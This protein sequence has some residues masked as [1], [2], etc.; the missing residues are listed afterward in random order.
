MAQEFRGP[1]TMEGLHKQNNSS[2]A[3]RAFG[4]VTIGREGELGLMFTNPA[5]LQ[6]LAGVQ[7][8][9][10]G[11]LR[12]Q[13]LEQ[14]QQ[15]APVRYYPNLSLLLE[16]M[17]GGIPDPDPDLI[18]FTPAD[19]VQRPFDD[20]R[21][22]WT[23]S[24]SSNAPLHALLAIPFSVGDVRITAGV[25]AVR[26]ADLD[27]YYQN[28]NLLE[29]AVLS[30]RPLPTLRP[31]DD[32]PLSV[33]WYQSIQSRQ[34]SVYGY[35]LA[36]AGYIAP[37]NLTVGLSG[38]LLDGESDDFEQLVR[39]GHLTFL[40]NEFR[41]DSSAGT[42]TRTGTSEFTGQE[43]TLSSVLDLQYVSV[44]FVL[45]PPTRFT[46][47]FELAVSGDAAGTPLMA[48]AAGEDEFQLPWRGSVGLMLKP[49]GDLRVG[50]EYEFR[51][52]AAATYTGVTDQESSPWRSS[53]LMRVGA[54]YDVLPWLAFRGGVRGEADVFVPEGSAITTDPVTYR[55]FS[56]GFG[57]SF[58]GLHWN[59]A[60]ESANME[61][62]DIW[63]SAISR[64]SNLQHLFATDI[65]YTIPFGR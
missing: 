56:V 59:F 54:E 23:R 10:S 44:G 40:A 8:S 60:F 49:R 20:I 39:R 22:N 2:A 18:G 41:A 52:Y 38:M 57:V 31:T 55:I 29:P 4:G 33:D 45:K 64:N 11:S 36:L 43:F 47:T 15:F 17:T 3:S 35:G 24:N 32:N 28:N 12:N 21:P 14:V 9:L 25:G 6:G 5:S 62:Q 63:G 13:D 16:N 19:S 53:S 26:Y 50:L 37:Y 42:V 51:P 7:L 30:Q 61:Y 46:R 58:S 65:S 27:H 48:P 34:G 1:L